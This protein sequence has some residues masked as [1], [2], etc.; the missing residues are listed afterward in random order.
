[1]WITIQNFS[2]PLVIFS[3][4]FRWRFSTICKHLKLEL[5]HATVKPVFQAIF[6]VVL[7]PMLNLFINFCSLQYF[8][9][10]IMVEA[11]YEQPPDFFKQHRKIF[12]YLVLEKEPRIGLDIPSGSN[13]AFGVH[14]STS[15]Y[16]CAF[17]KQ[18]HYHVLFECDSI[19]RK[20]Y[21]AP[22]LY[23]TFCLLLT[24][25]S[26]LVMQGEIMKRLQVAK[27]DNVKEK[28]LLAQGRRKVPLV[29][30]RKNFST[31]YAIEICFFVFFSPDL[32]MKISNF[33]ETVHTIFTKFCTVILHLMGPLRV[34]RHQNRMAGMSETARISPKNSHFSTFFDFL[35][36]CSYDSNEIFYSYSTPY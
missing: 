32:F 21:N 6:F 18:P 16:L 12:R 11:M 17:E 5:S 4:T 8:C 35:K 29:R 25:C 20:G 1:M 2:F 19:I 26:S 31:T 34:Q 13:Y 14:S 24:D 22:C 23:S 27:Q 15:D 3:H 9:R 33:S 36:N 30:S 28:A 7:W 10:R